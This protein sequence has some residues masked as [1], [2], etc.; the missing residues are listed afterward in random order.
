MTGN[1]RTHPAVAADDSLLECLDD[2]PSAA[3]AVSG[4][5]DS[6]ALMVLA[7]GYA[8]ARSR[9]LGTITVLTVDHGL[10][11]EA[12]AEAVAVAAVAARLGLA[13]VTLKWTGEKPDTGIQEAARFA[14]LDLMT[15]W[16]VA[17]DVG[18]L[19]LAHTLNDQAET[20]LMRLARGSGLD[21]LSSI[22][23]TGS[24]NGVKLLRPLLYVP[25]ENLETRLEREG[26]GWIED[27][28]NF[29][30]RFTRV[31]ARA[32]LTTLAE[33]G[34]SAD[35]LADAAGQMREARDALERATDAGARR[36][37][38]VY[39]AGLCTLDLGALAD[40]SRDI[41]ERLLRRTV[42]AVGARP[43]PPEWS[44]VSRLAD[45]VRGGAAGGRTLAGCQIARS[46][47]RLLVFRE[48]GREGLE[49]LA[50]EPGAR[51][52][53]DRRF[54]VAA[55]AEIPGPVTVRA[56]GSDGLGQLPREV[57]RPRS[58][59]A[60]AAHTLPS[61]WWRG[62]LVAVPHLR[63]DIERQRGKTPFTARFA[64]GEALKSGRHRE[65]IASHG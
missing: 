8:R 41:A 18:H 63:V 42:M 36:A 31:R 6:T 23:S 44:E 59:P 45:W 33:A 11:P 50:L 34:L 38:T 1:A 56:L 51:A 64:N 10:R 62:D 32:L 49:T 22:A 7:A 40:E 2:V 17:N 9:D 12:A 35:A 25:R 60:S 13:H 3:L 30:P 58:L 5:A 54:H 39:D 14:R 48:F 27:P 46:K 21:G 43:Y 16:C 37:L 52:V 26:I 28:S 47:D 61:F 20:F 55:P 19:V 15:G 57:V 53:W 65:I 29:D 24:W 4:G